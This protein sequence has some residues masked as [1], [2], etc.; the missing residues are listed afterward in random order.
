[1]TSVAEHVTLWVLYPIGT[2]VYQRHRSRKLAGVVTGLNVWPGTVCYQVRWG[3]G[4]EVSHFSIELTN[5][6]TP[7][8]LS[9]EE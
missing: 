8:Y 2:T 3:D 5:E 7:D 1:M 9:E 6:Y 4:T